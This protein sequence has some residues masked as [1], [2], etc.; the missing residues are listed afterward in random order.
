MLADA[1]ACRRWYYSRLCRSGI[2]GCLAGTIA[3]KAPVNPRALFCG[4]GDINCIDMVKCAVNACIWLYCIRAKQK[5]CTVSGCKAKEKPRQRGRG[6]MLLYL[7]ALNSAEKN[8][9]KNRM[10]EKITCCTPLVDHTA[11]TGGV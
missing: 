4:V 5:P 2:V 9:K 3:G 1:P 10:Q 8:Q 7:D 6:E 11:Q